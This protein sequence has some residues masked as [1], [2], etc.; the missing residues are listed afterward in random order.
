MT[1]FYHTQVPMSIQAAENG[2]KGG[3]A[4]PGK[5]LDFY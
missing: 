5:E 1:T 3:K 2:E 4:H